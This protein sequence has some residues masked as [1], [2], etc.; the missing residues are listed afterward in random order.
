MLRQAYLLTIP[1]T[2]YFILPESVGHYTDYPDHEVVREAG[3]LNNFNIHYVASGRG[4]VV[5]D[6]VVRELRKGQAFL[7]FP[8][9]AQ[10]YFSSKDDPWDVRWVHFYGSGL[11]DYMVER[12]LHQHQL[13]SLRQPEAWEQAH[14]TLLA[15]AEQ[16]SMLR[17][18]LL[19]TLSYALL[20]EFIQQAI[21]IE[22]V[23]G[24]RSE[25]RVA[26]L[27]PLMQQE[28]RQPFELRIWAERAGVSPHYFCKIFRD[29]AGMSPVQFITMSRLQYAKQRLLEQLDRN[30]GDIAV[31]AGYPSVS[32]FN[33]RFYQHEGMTPKEYRR[34]YKG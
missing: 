14:L 29:V 26:A 3:T 2:P 4:Y 13:W 30:I 12:G 34:L 24:G 25:S 17:P 1:H 31:E 11:H 19:S 15:E 7:Y 27:L 20:A 16:H 28:A 18:A 10:R 9:Q 8:L 21:P 23:R 5:I 32:Y 22:M 6:G 33:K